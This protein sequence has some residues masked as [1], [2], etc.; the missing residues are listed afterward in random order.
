M[1][2]RAPLRAQRVVGLRSLLIDTCLTQTVA[3]VVLSLHTTTQIISIAIDGYFGRLRHSYTKVSI[4]LVPTYL[5]IVVLF[6]L[7]FPPTSSNAQ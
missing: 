6:D 5:A 4:N 1:F 2:D 3:D 7:S